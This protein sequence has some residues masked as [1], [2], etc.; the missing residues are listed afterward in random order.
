MAPSPTRATSSV[1][2]WMCFKGAVLFSARF[3]DPSELVHCSDMSHQLLFD[4]TEE[5]SGVLVVLFSL[6]SRDVNRKLIQIT[7]DGGANLFIRRVSRPEIRGCPAGN[8]GHARQG[9]RAEFLVFRH[10]KAGP[11]PEVFKE[12]V[13]FRV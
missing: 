12:P 9:R 3:E 11:G 8:A 4:L 10:Q 5:G 1:P 2:R 7:E 6:G 13:E